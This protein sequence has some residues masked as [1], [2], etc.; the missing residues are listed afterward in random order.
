MEVIDR[1]SGAR[2]PHP[3]RFAEGRGG[4]D[5]DDLH[6]QA[7]LRGRANSQSPTP[8]WSRPSTTPT[9]WPVS[10]STRVVIQGS[11][12]VRALVAGS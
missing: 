3:Q 6:S 1:D 8:L 12:R 2:K 11:N 9:T 10:R 5:R 4:V 7:P